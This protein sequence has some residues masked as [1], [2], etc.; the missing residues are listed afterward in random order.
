M[1]YYPPVQATSGGPGSPGDVTSYKVIGV[2]GDSVDDAALYF[3]DATPGK[4]G[5]AGYDTSATGA[6]SSMVLQ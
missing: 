2:T 1:K 3:F 4:S 6:D 5:Y